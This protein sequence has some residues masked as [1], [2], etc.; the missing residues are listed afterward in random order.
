MANEL[1]TKSDKNILDSSNCVPLSSIL[2][3]FNAPINEEQCWA[4][5]HQTVRTV[6]RLNDK[7]PLYLLNGPANLYINKEGFVHEKSFTESGIVFNC[8]SFISC[9]FPP[10][11]F[12]V[13]LYQYE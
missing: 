7:R 4:L 13:F 10:L 11:F 8:Y 12:P 5:C 6:S 9:C 2:E 1:A 3:S